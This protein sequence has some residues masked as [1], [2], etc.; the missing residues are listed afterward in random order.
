[1]VTKV[2][3][4]SVMDLFT[5]SAKKNL[6]IFEKSQPVKKPQEI[7]VFFLKDSFSEKEDFI[8]VLKFSF[9]SNS[10]SRKMR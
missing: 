4:F 8:C 6:C 5:F 2:D 10:F 3:E 1:M 7:T 9:S